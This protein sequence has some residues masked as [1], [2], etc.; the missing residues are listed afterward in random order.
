[1][2]DVICNLSTERLLMGRKES[3]QTNKAMISCFLFNF[4]ESFGVFNEFHQ[5]SNQFTLASPSPLILPGQCLPP[6]PY[7]GCV[8]S[9]AN[10]TIGLPMSFGVQ[11]FVTLAYHW[12][13]WLSTSF[14]ICSKFCRRSRAWVKRFTR[15]NYVIKMEDL[16]NL[17]ADTSGI[18][19][20]LPIQMTINNNI[21]NV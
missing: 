4:F 19:T 20:I 16:K 7:S 13:H 9:Y 12:Y 14:T 3:K 21:T 5:S 8:R 2:C 10:S 6:A 17:A 18:T 11:P 1:M 15:E